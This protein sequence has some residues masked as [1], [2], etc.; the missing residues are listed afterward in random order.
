MNNIIFMTERHCFQNLSEVVTKTI[1][2]TLQDEHSPHF[3]MPG[4]LAVL[5]CSLSG[6]VQAL[7]WSL[8]VVLGQD[9]H[10]LVIT[11]TGE[12]MATNDSHA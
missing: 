7:L 4:R 6:L 1:R 8:C 11:C 9:T 2:S 10:L 5:G 3:R 12:C